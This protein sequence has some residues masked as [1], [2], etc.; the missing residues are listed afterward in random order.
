MT[1]LPDKDGI[2]RPH[3][4]RRRCLQCSK[5]RRV[6]G[7]TGARG[8]GAPFCSIACWQA[9]LAEAPVAKVT[10]GALADL[11]PYGWGIAGANGYVAP[12]HDSTDR[13]ETERNARLLSLPTIARSSGVAESAPFRVVQLF[14]LDSPTDRQATESPKVTLTVAEM[15]AAIGFAAPGGNVPGSDDLE[16][17]VTFQRQPERRSIEGETL[18]AGLYCWL[19]EYPDEGCFP[20]FD[21]TPQSD[22]STGALTKESRDA[23]L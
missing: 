21:C 10:V 17:E 23:D 19:T 18:P 3:G 15:F 22:L 16:A 9:F 4:E 14:Y 11:R 7:Y 1:F 5:V 12:R 20:L 8:E 2:R 6:R 13:E